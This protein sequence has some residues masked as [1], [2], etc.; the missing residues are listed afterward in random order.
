M[1][2]MRGWL[3][4]SNPIT[5]CI[6]YV[7]RTAQGKQHLPPL[8]LRDVGPS[9]F[10]ATGREFR[11][12]FIDIGKLQPDEDVLDIGCGSG[13]MALP[14]TSYLSSDGSY[15]GMDITKKSILWC[16]KHISSEFSNFQFYHSDLYN[17][18]YNPTGRY[19]TKE[20]TFPLEDERFDFIF[21]TSVFTHLL[22]DST[23]N[24]LQ[25]V[26]R[27]LR[28][29]GRALVTFFLLNESQQSLAAQG[30]NDIDFKF[31][32]GVYRMRDEAIPESAVA[33]QEEYLHEM[34]AS[35]RLSISGIIHYGRW[36]GRADS[37]SYQDILLVQR[38][39]E[40]R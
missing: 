35:A 5:N 2:A 26:A 7:V 30:R 31:G 8:Q 40:L 19:Q 28:P 6:D 12:Y 33:Y 39:N 15:V 38:S 20:Y 16:Q 3:A 27:L 29:D 37:L 24:Y 4:R 17:K 18:R 32:S 25:E 11:G 23:E 36:S 14:L 1:N 13:R 10:E 22:P 34:L 9:D 21:L